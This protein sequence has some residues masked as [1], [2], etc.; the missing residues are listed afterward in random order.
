MAFSIID[1]D[2]GFD[3]L[4]D[5][6]GSNNEPDYG[7]RTANPIKANRYQLIIYPFENAAWAGEAV[8]IKYFLMAKNLWQRGVIFISGGT[9]ANPNLEHTVIDSSFNIGIIGSYITPSIKTLQGQRGVH[10]QDSSSGRT[11][12][13]IYYQVRSSRAE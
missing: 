4:V 3:R 7:N 11:S 8:L 6:T 13:T 1:I 5:P 12:F 9:G 2:D 10:I